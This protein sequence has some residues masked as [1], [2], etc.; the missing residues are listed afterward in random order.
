MAEPILCLCGHF[1]GGSCHCGCTT[2]QPDTEPCDIC[3][4]HGC[5]DCYEGD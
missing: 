5:A 1:H 3:A 4:G 2:Y